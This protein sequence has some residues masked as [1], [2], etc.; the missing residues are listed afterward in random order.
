MPTQDDTHGLVLNE[1]NKVQSG[2]SL[3]RDLSKSEMLKSSNLDGVQISDFYIS[4]GNEDCADFNQGADALFLNG[5]FNAR[6][7]KQAL[8]VKGGFNGFKVD[9]VFFNGKPKNGHIILGQYSD[10][11]FHAKLR[12][13]NTLIENCRFT[14]DSP[15]VVCWN[16]DK[17]TFVNCMGK[18]EVK[19]VHPVIVW[20]Y[21]T[22]R[23]IQ[24]RFVFGRNG[25]GKSKEGLRK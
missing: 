17:P 1:S 13:T 2:L 8:T 19:V 25:R 18:P 20:A 11:D 7:A 6:G 9:N 23:K 10:Y 3:V 21:F 14:P 22:F 12:T 15:A 16:A 5:E 4:A 24:Q